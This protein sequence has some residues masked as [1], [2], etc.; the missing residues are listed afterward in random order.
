MDAGYAECIRN[1]SVREIGLVE[2]LEPTAE[3]MQDI[4]A[5]PKLAAARR[6]FLEEWR[7]KW[8]PLPNSETAP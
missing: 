2:K 5:S 7:E 4:A 6:L 8:T 1:L 3:E